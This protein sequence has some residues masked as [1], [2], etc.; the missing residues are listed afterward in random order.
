MQPDVGFDNVARYSVAPPKYGD[1]V[2]M[3]VL[4]IAPKKWLAMS[5]ARALHLHEVR[6]YEEAVA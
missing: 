5:S 4:Q 1:A 6:K 2:A 3:H